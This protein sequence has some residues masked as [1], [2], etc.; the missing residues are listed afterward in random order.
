[1]GHGT[2]MV[3]L[4]IGVP[5]ESFLALALLSHDAARGARCTPWPAPT[6]VPAI[7]WVG[8]ELFTFLAL[9]P[10]FVQWLRF[11]GRK[12]ATRRRRAR[13]VLRRGGVHDPHAGRLR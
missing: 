4:L 3:A 6:R 13:C 2:K 11:E 10:V 1:M 9:I 8:A 7:L 5:L 12:T